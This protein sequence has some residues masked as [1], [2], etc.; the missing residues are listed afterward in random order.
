MKTLC[1]L[2]GIITL[3][4]A[5]SG[6]FATT[7]SSPIYNPATGHNYFLLAGSTWT[8]AESQALGL[9]GYLATVNDAAEESWIY[10]TFSS[11]GSVSRNLWIGL[12]SGAADGSVKSNYYWVNGEISTYQ[13]WYDGQPIESTEH[14]IEIIG[15]GN[16][17]SGGWNNLANVATDGYSGA[18]LLPM[19]GV[20]EVVPEPSIGGLLVLGGLLAFSRMH[21]RG[22]R[23][24][25]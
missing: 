3:V 14:Y 2:I 1:T 5:G 24:P 23:L 17:A 18:T 21:G 16:F 22:Q 7:I 6:A 9:G 4:L 12:T 13:N 15:P 8:D 11:Y 10:S 20:V 25:F 19:C